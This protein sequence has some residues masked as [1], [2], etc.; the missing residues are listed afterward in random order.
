MQV[1]A[2][3]TQPPIVTITPNGVYI[4]AVGEYRV[5]VVNGASL[6]SAFTLGNT[7]SASG[8]V[9]CSIIETAPICQR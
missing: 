4:Q 8:Q 2:M 6:I 1:Q 3:A 7:V 9:G 5:F